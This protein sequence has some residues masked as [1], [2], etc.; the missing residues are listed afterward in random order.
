VGG[1]LSDLGCFSQPKKQNKTKQLFVLYSNPK[2]K[3]EKIILFFV[4]GPEKLFMVNGFFLDFFEN[5]HTKEE[6]ELF[7]GLY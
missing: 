5:S 7:V 2:E 6:E 3:E 1:G 4:C